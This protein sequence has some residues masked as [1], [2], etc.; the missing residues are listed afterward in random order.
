MRA[1][2]GSRA[3]EPTVWARAIAAYGLDTRLDLGGRRLDPAIF[4]SV[5]MECQRHRLVG[6]FACAVDDEAVTLEPKDHDQLLEVVRSW[7]ANQV[8]VE[9]LL[10]RVADQLE[11]SGIDFRVLKG[12]ALAHGTYA[13][14]E[15]RSFGDLD[16]LVPAEHFTRAAVVLATGLRGRRVLAELRPGFDARFGREIL[17][18]VDSLELDLHR[19]LVDGYFGHAIV[20]DD[21]FDAP[22]WF[23]LAGTRLPAL[24]LAAQFV[25]SCSSAVLGNS[26]PRLI[27]QRD[28]QQLMSAEGFDVGQ[29][30]LLARRWHS[31][32][33]VTTAIAE[34]ARALALRDADQ[35]ADAARFPPVHTRDK[36]LIAAYRNRFSGKTSHASAL[37]AIRGLRGQL[38]YGRAIAMPQRSFRH[39]RCELERSSR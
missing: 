19:T 31:T 5:L 10:F 33:V 14:P 12:T 34:S 22:S 11:R 37:L 35:R 7:H 28:V 25:H 39:D 9:Q 26:T 3:T 23:D 17:L 27:S 38:S 29:P 20:L 6:L 1:P 36:A 24:G 15:L 18:K 21:L 4:M 2:I 30:L 16:I 32:A 8:R 13:D